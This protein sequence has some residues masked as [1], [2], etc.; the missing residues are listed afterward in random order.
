MIFPTSITVSGFRSI[1]APVTLSLVPGAFLVV[2]ANGSGKS[3]LYREALHFALYNTNLRGRFIE[4]VINRDSDECRVEVTFTVPGI[5]A[6]VLT[7]VRTRKGKTEVTFVGPAGANL[8][9]G[10]GTTSKG[11][12]DPIEALLGMAASTVRATSFYSPAD[13]FL[14]MT[15]TKRRELLEDSFGLGWLRDAKEKAAAAHQESVL[16]LGKAT[17]VAAYAKAKIETL[18]ASRAVL[19]SQIKA[20]KERAAVNVDAEIARITTEIE[21]T[22]ATISEKR[23]AR[24]SQ[25]ALVK[26]AAQ[27]T[28]LCR[29]E[30]ERVC[31]AVNTMLTKRAS[32][33]SSLAGIKGTA[34][35]LRTSMERV[36]G[37]EG[38]P[39]ACP[40]C[41]RAF[42]PDDTSAKE[43][44]DRLQV[45]LAA[46]T[47][48][49]E[50][51]VSDLA[52]VDGAIDVLRTKHTEA[53][54]A[55]NEA[56]LKETDANAALAAIDRVLAQ[57]CAEINNR[58][59]PA[60]RAL[61]KQRAERD[62]SAVK[63]LEE[64]LASV[65]TQLKASADSASNSA[66]A[67]AVISKEVEILAWWKQAF[68]PKGIRAF[69]LEAT[70]PALSKLASYYL[71]RMTNYQLTC[72]ISATSTTQKGKE[73]ET[74][75]VVVKNVGGIDGAL[76]LS[77][78]ENR[79][80]DLAIHLA[81]AD[82]CVAR[83]GRGLGYAAFDESLDC[84]SPE[85]VSA[86]CE[87]LNDLGKR[88]MA[89]PVVAFGEAAR[90]Q[91]SRCVIVSRGADGWTT[92]KED[93]G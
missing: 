73:V 66:V 7:R 76:D 67:V 53:T 11:Q 42:A 52:T 69:V 78:G 4:N 48:S 9:T 31:Q 35:R 55:R 49:M 93:A 16:A 64:N 56:A 74:L 37:R 85:R 34:E 54:A 1:K 84:L 44:L 77:A 82:L 71:G 28:R 38:A 61:E 92:M 27:S 12:V 23:A 47:Q 59:A 2:G 83:A 75:D 63:A 32:A 25:E 70:L 14:N 62:D 46:A 15:D 6:A 41:L 65:E 60:L 24:D 79:V 3:T 68:G 89:C 51:L 19:E 20:A 5:G 26:Q 29:E 57:L 21:T 50:G 45:E 87:I 8:L 90:D 17:E 91:F 30:A 88:G 40:V 22:N 86:V 81:L 13:G 36:V 39:P 43:T 10:S 18:Q 33:A 72:V 80:V 58:L